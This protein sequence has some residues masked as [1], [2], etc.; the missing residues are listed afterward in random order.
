MTTETPSCLTTIKW[1]PFVAT[2]GPV[3]KME[4]LV[5]G[6]DGLFNSPKRLELRQSPL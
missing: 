4:A 6:T 1:K 3:V 2:E 5:R